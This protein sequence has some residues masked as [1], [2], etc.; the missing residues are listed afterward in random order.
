M[1]KF[2]S[3]KT[4]KKYYKNTKSYFKKITT[5]NDL[6]LHICNNP[7][8]YVHIYYFELKALIALSRLKL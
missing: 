8:K 1:I 7:I 4:K 6:S 2:A 3:K 5:Y